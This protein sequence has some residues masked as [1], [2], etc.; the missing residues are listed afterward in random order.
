M[1]YFIV[2]V[3]VLVVMAALLAL[4]YRLTGARGPTDGYHA[5]YDNV[6]GIKYGTVTYYKGFQVG[7]VER[8]EPQ[9][10][11]DGSG[12]RYR[13]QFSVKQGWPIPRGSVAAIVL[14]GPLAPAVVDIR[15]GA[16]PDLLAPGSELEGAEP[17]NLFAALNDVAADFRKLSEQGIQPTLRNLNERVAAL[18]AE[19]ENLSRSE[20][21]PL[22]RQLRARL[23]DPEL[24]ESFTQVIDKLDASAEAL[25]RVLSDENQQHLAAILSNAD[26]GS[27]QLNDVLARIEDTRA[28]MHHLL[29]QL[30]QIV[31]E[32]RG[33][34]TQGVGDAAAAMQD[35]RDSV[36][37]VA[38]NVDTIV[39][40]L[41][42]GTRNMNEFSRE[43]RE[44]PGILLRGTS[45]QDPLPA[46][47]DKR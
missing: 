44:N 1:N 17:A 7:Q 26:R 33:S 38:D 9:L 22:V 30:D 15:E 19:Y 27:A 43:I 31:A 28:R 8:I 12:T 16:G 37:T 18:S 13:V 46:S 2:G 10:Q 24:L 36:R 25:L 5:F 6:A 32:N 40:Y 11:Q 14:P 39:H 47:A 35:L 4:L 21:R 34:L 41:E 20:L 23:D 42:S 29:E 3:F 45:P